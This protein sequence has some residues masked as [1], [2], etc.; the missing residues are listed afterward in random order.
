MDFVY[1]Y[2][3]YKKTPYLFRSLFAYISNNKGGKII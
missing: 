3:I 2:V 1:E